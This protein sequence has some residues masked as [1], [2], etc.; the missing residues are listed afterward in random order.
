MKYIF[1]RCKKYE[2]FNFKRIIYILWNEVFQNLNVKLA[3][4][5]L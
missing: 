4:F 1:L 2:Q 3:K 5:N